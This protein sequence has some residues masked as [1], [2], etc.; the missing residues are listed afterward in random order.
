MIKIICIESYK[1]TRTKKSVKKGT[2]Y[3]TVPDYFFSFIWEIIPIYNDS[4]GADFVA[5]FRKKNFITLDKWREQQI[6]KILGND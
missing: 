5:T 4:E 2:I 6:D 1:F 3:Y